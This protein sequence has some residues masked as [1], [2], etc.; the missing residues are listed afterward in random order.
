MNKTDHSMI[1]RV[2]DGENTIFEKN[3]IPANLLYV[4]LKNH[5]VAHP[6]IDVSF[7]SAETDPINWISASPNSN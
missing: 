5:I 4:F 6:T 7:D 2:C 3:D 1:V